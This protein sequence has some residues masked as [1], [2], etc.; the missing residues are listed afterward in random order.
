MPWFGIRP[1]YSRLGQ[2]R[3]WFVGSFL[4]TPPSTSAFLPKGFADLTAP[5]SIAD[6]AGFGVILRFVIRRLLTNPAVT[7]G[8]SDVMTNPGGY[9]WSTHLNW[10]SI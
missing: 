6:M 9:K 1:P 2:R 3:Q 8:M 5:Q 10:Y 4:S 7:L